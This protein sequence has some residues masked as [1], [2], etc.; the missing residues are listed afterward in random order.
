MAVRMIDFCS[1]L[2]IKHTF[3]FH[4]IEPNYNLKDTIK[5]AVILI[6]LY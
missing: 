4:M 5:V 2:D 3:V 1:K 6:I